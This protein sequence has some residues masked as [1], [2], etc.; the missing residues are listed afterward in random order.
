MRASLYDI[1]LH[2]LLEAAVVCRQEKVRQM[3]TYLHWNSNMPPICRL[4]SRQARDTFHDRTHG[5]MRPTQRR[6]EGNYNFL[7][8]LV[9]GFRFKFYGYIIYIFIY[10]FCF[11]W[12]FL[13]AFWSLSAGAAA[14]AAPGC[15]C[16]LSMAVCAWSLGIGAVA[17]CYCC[18]QLCFAIWGLCWRNWLDIPWCSETPSSSSKA[19]E[20]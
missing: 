11:W 19:Q 17:G 5:H 2:P 3:A 14:S 10:L 20:L 16:R 13:C 6:S 15:C 8:R 9:L 7:V 4:F 18:P 12:I 1:P